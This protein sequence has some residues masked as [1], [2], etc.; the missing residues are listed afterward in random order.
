[1][2][3]LPLKH[4]IGNDQSWFTSGCCGFCSSLAAEWKRQNI[5]SGHWQSLFIVTLLLFWLGKCITFYS[6][7]ILQ[8][9]LN[10]T[11]NRKSSFQEV[12]FWSFLF[13]TTRPMMTIK[14]RTVRAPRIKL[15]SFAVP[16]DSAERKRIELL[17]FHL[18]AQEL[19][20]H[21]IFYVE[22]YF[23]TSCRRHHEIHRCLL[24]K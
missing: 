6:F 16:S 17:C 21:S 7:N 9:N 13:L 1:M 2:P 19:W 3:L 20:E 5:Q 24:T 22:S 8:K 4:I 11:H 10:R 15:I 14:R 18:L 23:Q 12:P